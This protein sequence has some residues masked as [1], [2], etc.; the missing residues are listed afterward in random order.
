MA[1]QGQEQCG[2][3]GGPGGRGQQAIWAGPVEGDGALTQAQHALPIRLVVPPLAFV[4]VAV[5]VVRAAPPAALVAA[6]LTLVILLGSE[7]LDPIALKAG[8]YPCSRRAA[9]TRKALPSSLARKP[10]T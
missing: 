7:K 1:T 3:E 4:D 2:F 8:K 10:H 5:A 6:P 9:T